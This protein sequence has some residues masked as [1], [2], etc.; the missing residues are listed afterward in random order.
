MAIDHAD[1]EP[2]RAVS[3]HPPSPAL[4]SLALAIYRMRR[5]RDREMPPALLGEPAWDMLLALYLEL[6][7]IGIATF[8]FGSGVPHSTAMRWV[9][10]LEEAGLALRTR[11]SEPDRDMV[12]LTPQGQHLLERSLRAMS[13]TPNS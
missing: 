8:C 3:V 12:S 9:A 11:S 5:A 4:S 13:R 10:A 7:G 1:P 2:L 6:P